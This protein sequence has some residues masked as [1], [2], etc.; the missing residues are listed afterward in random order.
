MAR[1]SQVISTNIGSTNIESDT[2]TFLNINIYTWQMYTIKHPISQSW[3]GGCLLCC[4]LHHLILNWLIL[5][6]DLITNIANHFTN[7]SFKTNLLHSPTD[8]GKMGRPSWTPSHR[9][10]NQLHLSLDD[11]DAILWRGDLKCC[12]FCWRRLLSAGANEDQDLVFLSSSNQCWGNLATKLGQRW[13]QRW[14]QRE[15]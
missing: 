9:R 13:G 8:L 4:C 15:K 1:F 2:T 7:S 11:I 5:S 3:G 6:L 14:G 12:H 10:D